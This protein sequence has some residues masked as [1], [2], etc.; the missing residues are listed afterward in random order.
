[1]AIS[2]QAA[3]QTSEQA[4]SAEVARHEALIDEVLTADPEDSGMYWYG[5]SGGNRMSNAVRKVLTKRYTNAGWVVEFVSDQRDGDALVFS[6]SRLVT[7]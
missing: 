7:K 3:R 1:M 5:I 4:N 2:P 6:E